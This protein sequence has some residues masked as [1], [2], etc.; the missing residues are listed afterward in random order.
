MNGTLIISRAEFCVLHAARLC[1]LVLRRSVIPH[2]ADGTLKRNNISHV[3]Y[4]PDPNFRDAWP[5]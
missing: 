4:S 3:T 5:I 2:L 1:A